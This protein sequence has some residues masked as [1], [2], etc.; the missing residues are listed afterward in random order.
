MSN[1]NASLAPEDLGHLLQPFWRKDA[2]RAD[3]SHS[4]LGLALV[5]AYA[6]LLGAEISLGLDK[7][8]R[9]GVK[10]TFPAS[11]PRLASDERHGD[12]MARRAG[13]PP[14][15]ASPAPVTTAARDEDFSGFRGV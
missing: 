6:R 2:A 8:D 13:A 14:D 1:T 4:G 7:V 9:F 3:P 12:A 5:A 10:L 15:R 11:S